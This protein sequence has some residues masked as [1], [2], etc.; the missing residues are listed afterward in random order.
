VTSRPAFN[1]ES[2]TETMSRSGYSEDYDNDWTLIKWRGQVASAIRGRRGQALL[3]ELL[4]ALDA[5]PVKRLI[6]HELREGPK[7]YVA[8]DG[9]VIDRAYVRGDV[10]A[11]G[12]LGARRGMEMDDL[13][14]E[15]PDTIAERFGVA[16]QLVREIEWMNDEGFWGTPEELWVKMRHWVASQVK[17][18]PILPHDGSETNA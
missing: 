6:S 5:M 11:L 7:V 9:Q 2:E 18:S 15:D 12:S 13:D 3:R 14:P 10:C 17:A 16:H 4:A 1:P 8:R